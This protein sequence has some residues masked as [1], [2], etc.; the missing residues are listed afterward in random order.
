MSMSN[1]IDIQ[2]LLCALFEN[3]NEPAAAADDIDY[4]I[5]VGEEEPSINISTFGSIESIFAE[6]DDSLLPFDFEEEEEET[7]QNTE[8]E[9]IH[10]IDSI[11]NDD[12]SANKDK[13]EGSA[14]NKHQFIGR[15]VTFEEE[16]EELADGDSGSGTAKS[17]LKEIWDNKW[18]QRYDDLV[19]STF[20]TIFDY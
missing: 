16:E 17:N 9:T 11:F 12:V 1:D 6:D 2:M 7:M 3:E 18:K 15:A 14:S 13:G 20:N 8:E 4:L 5:T 19:V 10:N